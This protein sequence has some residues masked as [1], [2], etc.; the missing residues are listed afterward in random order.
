MTGESAGANIAHNMG[1]RLGEQKIDGI[2]VSG[3]ILVHP[4]FRG[5][6]PLPSEPVLPESKSSFNTRFWKAA[7][8]TSTGCDDPLM[9]PAKDPKLSGMGCSRILVYVTEK[10]ELRYRGWYYKEVLSKS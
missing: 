5:E 3:I 8:P 2:E 6:E 9:N 4:Y 1:I 7:S 10:D